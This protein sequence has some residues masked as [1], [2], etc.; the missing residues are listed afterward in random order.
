[1]K[2]LS[3]PEPR[4]RSWPVYTERQCMWCPR[5][6]RLS[7]GAWCSPSHRQFHRGFEGVRTSRLQSPYSLKPIATVWPRNVYTELMNSISFPKYIRYV[8][9]TD[10]LYILDHDVWSSSF[11]TQGSNQQRPCTILLAHLKEWNGLEGRG[12]REVLSEKFNVRETCLQ[13]YSLSHLFQVL[14]FPTW[15]EMTSGP[16]YTTFQ[17]NLT[18][19]RWITLGKTIQCHHLDL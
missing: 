11:C 5:A 3:Q 2:P 8:P 19:P 15:L 16:E 14:G 12:R 10:L 18:K 1:M 13:I 17:K 4:A 6:S 7:L 9:L